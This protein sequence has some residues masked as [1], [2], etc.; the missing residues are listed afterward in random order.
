MCHVHCCVLKD[1][2]VHA[3]YTNV[4]LKR[5]VLTWVAGEMLRDDEE[6][7]DEQMDAART[8]CRFDANT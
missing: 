5:F 8:L 6:S 2:G 7:E 1:T 4:N 3:P